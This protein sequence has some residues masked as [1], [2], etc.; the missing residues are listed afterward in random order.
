[1]FF[2]FALVSGS[3]QQALHQ[4]DIPEYRLPTTLQ[5]YRLPIPVINRS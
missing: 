4:P 3:K 1:L 5:I 2:L